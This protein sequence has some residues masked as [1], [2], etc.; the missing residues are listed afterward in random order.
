[1]ERH[2]EPEVHR[3]YP[4]PQ[5][6]RPT[7]E[8]EE[9]ERECHEQELRAR[10]RHGCEAT[11]ADQQHREHE[12]PGEEREDG[13]VPG[14]SHGSATASSQASIQ[15]AAMHAAARAMPAVGVRNQ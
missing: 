5:P 4:A 7:L 8:E 15:A 10:R 6:R 3:G 1:M 12:P 14:R 9:S 11:G 13:T 2:E